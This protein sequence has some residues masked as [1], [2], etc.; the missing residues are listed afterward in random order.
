MRGAADVAKEGTIRE[1]RRCRSDSAAGVDVDDGEAVDCCA[2]QG[3]SE[4]EDAV[5]VRHIRRGR[6]TLP[7]PSAKFLPYMAETYWLP[8]KPCLGDAGLAADLE[9]F[10]VAPQDEV[11]DAGDG[12]RTVDGRVAAGDDVD[13]LDEVVRDRVDVRRHGVVEN[14][15]GDV[16]AA[17]DQ[18]QRALTCRGREGRAG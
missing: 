6:V 2:S 13:A 17:V 1:C 12:V 4:R 8:P 7:R 15:G 14:V 3:M 11:D 9:A 16:A 18:H 5:L 10:E